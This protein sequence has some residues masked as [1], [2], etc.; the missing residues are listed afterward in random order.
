MD[1]G[2]DKNNPD[3]LNFDALIELIDELKESGYKIG[4]S[5]YI[6]AQDLILMLMAQGETLDTPEKLRNLLG[7]IVCSSPLE[8]EDFQQRFNRWLNLHKYTPA[9]VGNVE[10]QAQAQELSSELA[11]ERSL[12]YEVQNLTFFISILIFLSILLFP[13]LFESANQKQPFIEPTATTEPVPISTQTEPLPTPTGILPTV[14]QEQPSNTPFVLQVLLLSLAIFISLVLSW[15]SLWRLWWFWRANLFLERHSTNQ[16][17][18]LQKISLAGLEENLIPNTL[19]LKIA[20]GLRYRVPASSR[21]LDVNRTIHATLSQGGWLTPVY[22]NYQVIPEYLFLINRTSYRDHQAKFIEEIIE[23]LQ[24]EGVFITIYFFD[25]DPRICFPGTG[26]SSPLRLREIIS[27]YNDHRLVIIS[28]TRNFF[29]SV[30]GELS[31]WVN[32]LTSWENRSVLTPTPAENWSYQELELAQKFIIL[33]ATLKGL[34]VLSQRL[35]WGNATYYLVQEVPAP[36][37]DTLALQPYLWIERNSPPTDQVN[38]MLASLEQYLGKDGFY[39]LSA[40]AIFP[41]LHWNITIYL[42]N[43]LQSEDR[44]PLIE[45]CSVTDLARLPWLRY[46]YIPDWLRIY[47]ITTLSQEQQQIIRSVLQDLLVTAVQGS[48]SKL[49]LKIAQQYPNILPNLVKPILHLLSKKFS[50][51]SQLQDYIFLAFMAKKSVLSIKV[52]DEFSHLLQ[53]QKRNNWLLILLRKM[54][55]SNKAL[56]YS[57]SHLS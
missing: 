41:Q 19:I 55:I 33:P 47:L 8:Q 31:S 6:A 38:M 45:S 37:P 53:K 24:A 23:R 49:Q 15:W 42:G 48:V 20:Q 16:Q 22:R 50:D 36:L 29:S 5:Q 35:R 13:S 28:E 14:P 57:R 12:F 52:E 30:T 9:A 3:G 27:K 11:K 26:E 56:I 40:C 2:T 25:D 43:V 46:G 18:E 39:W 34:E 4:I 54:G 21:E 44:E 32:Q 10:T 7:P 1:R 51:N 17:P